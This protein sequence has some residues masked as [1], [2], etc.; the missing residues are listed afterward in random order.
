MPA[1]DLLDELGEDHKSWLLVAANNFLVQQRADHAVVLLELLEL[2]DPEDAQCQKLLAYAH[3]L[4]GDGER[5]AGAA[6]RLL[7]QPLSDA[8]REAVDFMRGHPGGSGPAMIQ[9]AEPAGS[10]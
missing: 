10:A 5:L 1:P 3:W 6:E 9:R 4:Q 8:E 7:R 2:L